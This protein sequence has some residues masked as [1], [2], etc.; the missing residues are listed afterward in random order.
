MTDNS[1]FKKV[2]L[3]SKSF[4]HFEPQ[5]TRGARWFVSVKTGN[6]LDS[7]IGDFATEAEA[8]H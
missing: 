1:R 4:P 5:M 7:H 3:G 2:A 6:G 8:R